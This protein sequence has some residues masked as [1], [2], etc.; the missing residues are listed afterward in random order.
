MVLPSLFVSVLLL[1]GLPQPADT[2]PSPGTLKWVRGHV[3]SID[4]AS[5][6]LTLKDKPFAASVT[7][8][9]DVIGFAGATSSLAKVAPGSLVEVHF[10]EKAGTRLAVLVVADMP[11]AGV[12]LSNRTGRSYRG[13]VRQAKR[14]S[15][16]LRVESRNR[17]VKLD[18]K[19]TLTDLDGR[20]L[21]TGT[22][23]VAASLT[24]GSLVLVTYDERSED[25]IAGDLFLPGSSQY[26][27]QI[28]RLR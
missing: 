15:V 27:L 14:S 10:T 18:K 23:E 22:K 21:A 4:S 7:P 13:I 3:T 9:T 19:T 6:A 26:A 24:A 20:P 25:I 2:A 1:A 17:G 28:R 12:K 16:S 11:S 5:I 8:S